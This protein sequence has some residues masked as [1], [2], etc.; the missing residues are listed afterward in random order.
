VGVEMDG[1]T[2]MMVNVGII[3]VLVTLILRTRRPPLVP[4]VGKL[5]T[6]HVEQRLCGLCALRGGRLAAGADSLVLLRP[7]AQCDR[8]LAVAAAAV[9]S[10]TPRC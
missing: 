10:R 8:S 9:L 5:R 2:V 4:P 3:V 1:D 7:D 6:A